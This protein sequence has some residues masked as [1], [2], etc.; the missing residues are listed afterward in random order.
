M[1]NIMSE[2]PTDVI[3][4]IPEIIE[5]YRIGEKLVMVTAYD[6]PSAR[7]AEL[8]GVDIVLVGDSGAMTVLGHEST[9]MITIDEM[10]MFCKA[11]RRGIRSPF[12]VGD[13]PYGSYEVSDEQAVQTAFRFI[14]EAGCDA[15][16]LEGCGPMSISRARAIVQAGIPVVGH[17]GLTPQT[18]VTLGGY[19][20]Q[21]KNAE[22]ASL[23]IQGA[24]ALQGAGCFCLVLEAIPSVVA[25]LVV[26]RIEVPTIGIGAGPATSGQVL[27]F[28][29][30]L[31]I[32][33][34]RD[35]KFVRRYADLL[36][37]MKCGITDF[38]KEV[39]NREYPT[40]EHEYKMDPQEADT[41]RSILRSEE[42]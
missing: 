24:L 12:M 26:E 34:G 1:A 3:L 39:R 32:G 2:K 9:T 41:L 28:H 23:L 15:V 29:D 4:G 8:A 20:A 5:K 30:L 6:Y 35:A 42:D 27:V 14:K 11:V 21:A 31:G 33:E 38:A 16:K 22:A 25:E 40:T 13:L 36:E 37:A 7:A 19:R 17:V 18:A 10:L